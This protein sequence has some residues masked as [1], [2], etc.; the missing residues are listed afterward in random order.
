M[1]SAK[2]LQPDIDRIDGLRPQSTRPRPV[3]AHSQSTHDYPAASFG[4]RAVA[5]FIDSFLGKIFTNLMMAIV[6]MM[7]SGLIPPEGGVAGDISIDEAMVYLGVTLLVALSSI[8]FVT[9]VPMMFTG[10]SP[11][12]MLMRIK[13]ISL[14]GSELG[15]GQIIGRETIAKGFS[16]VLLGI[17]YLMALR[18]PEK[19]AWHDKKCDTRVVSI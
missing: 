14:R 6:A 19:R 5:L 12:K 2:K 3:L 11:G 8:F 16:G 7:D 18:D 13:V 17:G 4:S 10:Q 1:S 9:C 15:I